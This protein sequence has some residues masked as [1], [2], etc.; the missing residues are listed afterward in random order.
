MIKLDQSWETPLD[1]DSQLVA[2]TDSVGPRA[3]N[4]ANG[5]KH[6][7]CPLRGVGW[8]GVGGQVIH[9]SF[10]ASVV[11]GV[12]TASPYKKSLLDTV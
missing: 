10:P 7:E 12:P 2:S 3:E 1:L 11:G 4:K 8:D 6:S 9:I 5:R